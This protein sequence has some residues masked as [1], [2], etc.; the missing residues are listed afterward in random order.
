M[1]AVPPADAGAGEGGP[2][3][4]GDVDLAKLDTD[5]NPQIANAFHIQGIPAVKAFRDGKV[6]AEF[7][8]A[9]PP[10]QVARFFDALVPSEAEGLVAEGGEENLRRALE[11]EPGAPRPPSRSRGSWPGA[12]SREGALELLDNAPAP[13][14][15]GPG[16]A[17][18]AR[19]RP[20]LPEAF[21]SLDAGEKE[22]GSTR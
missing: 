18:A 2:P 1:R 10:A 16:G 3:A 13:R 11:L 20:E 4:R 17:A 5:A 8:G 19:G 15:R 22:A 6:V 7:V 14:R 12:A 9:Q 21:A